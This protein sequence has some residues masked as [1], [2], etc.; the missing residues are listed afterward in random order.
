MLEHHGHPVGVPLKAV[1]GRGGLGA[2]GQEPCD[3]PRYRDVV[4]LPFLRVGRRTGDVAVE[5]A[6]KLDRSTEQSASEVITTTSGPGI[7]RRITA[8]ASRSANAEQKRSRTSSSSVSLAASGFTGT[9]AGAILHDGMVPVVDDFCSSDP[10]TRRAAV[11][12]LL[13]QRRSRTSIEPTEN[14]QRRASPPSQSG[15][16]VDQMETPA[17]DERRARG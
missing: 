8:P 10:I 12:T 9:G 5:E 7:K 2:V 4:A 3:R 16:V 14:Y 11:S 15:R 17:R 1:L 13:P 6:P